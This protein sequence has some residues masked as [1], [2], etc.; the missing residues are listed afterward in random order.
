MGLALSV[1]ER[2]NRELSKIGAKNTNLISFI[3]IRR[4]RMAVSV[5]RLRM[6][7]GPLLF[8]KKQTHFAKDVLGES[9]A[10]LFSLAAPLFKQFFP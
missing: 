5:R 3:D 6:V 10:P 9:G 4:L 2:F 1:L 8:A 7:P